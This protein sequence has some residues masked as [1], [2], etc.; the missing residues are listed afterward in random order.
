MLIVGSESLLYP[1]TALE[2]STAGFTVGNA[3]EGRLSGDLITLKD[4]Q[5]QLH[6]ITKRQKY[7]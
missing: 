7:R 4:G 3:G 5:A 1:A 6:L 2:T